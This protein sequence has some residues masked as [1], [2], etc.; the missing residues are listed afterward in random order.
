ME[1]NSCSSEPTRLRAGLHKGGKPRVGE[2][3]RSWLPHLARKGD[4]IKMRDYDMD[5]LVTTPKRVTS[6]TWDPTPQCKQALK[7]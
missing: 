6:P 2:V 4:Q 5:R 3:T 1:K 7:V